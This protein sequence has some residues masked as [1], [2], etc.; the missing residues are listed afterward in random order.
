MSWRMNK[1]QM[2]ETVFLT[3]LRFQKRKDC[4][5]DAPLALTR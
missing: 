1:Q 3:F 2:R 5:L 4:E